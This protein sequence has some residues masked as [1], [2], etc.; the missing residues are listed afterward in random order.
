[1]DALTASYVRPFSCR[2]KI[3][4]NWLNRYMDF[5]WPPD[6]LAERL[7]LPGLEVVGL[8]APAGG[9]PA[10]HADRMLSA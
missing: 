3:T 10:W 2:M 5:D 1:M 9:L 6:K 4:L 7:T 8:A